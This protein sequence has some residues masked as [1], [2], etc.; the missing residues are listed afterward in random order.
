MK[1]EK[2]FTLYLLRIPSKYKWYV[3]HLDE[4][5]QHEAGRRAKWLGAYTILT[6]WLT[7]TSNTLGDPTSLA[8]LAIGTH[9]HIPINIIQNKSL[10]D[11][12]DFLSLFVVLG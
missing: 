7:T 8:S 2:Y 6:E 5:Y 12:N 9:M 1:E 11:N 4:K 3:C 10:K